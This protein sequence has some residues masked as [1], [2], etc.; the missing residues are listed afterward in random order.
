[1]Y[2]DSFGCRFPYSYD[3]AAHALVVVFSRLNLFFHF[4]ESRVFFQFFDIMG[5][6]SFI[7]FDFF[8][9]DRPCGCSNGGSRFCMRRNSRETFA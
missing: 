3:F 9:F 1:M 2:F 8:F 7:L 5:Q 4:F 6:V